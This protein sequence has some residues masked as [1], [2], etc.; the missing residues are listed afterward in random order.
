MGSTAHALSEEEAVALQ[1]RIQNLCSALF[2]VSK[3][4]QPVLVISNADI[5]LCSTDKPCNDCSVSHHLLSK[6]ICTDQVYLNSLKR[7]KVFHNPKK[8]L[9][10][11]LTAE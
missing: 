5:S 4:L 10:G 8:W 11:Y 1:L 2:S 6:S 9:S 7:D 3:Q